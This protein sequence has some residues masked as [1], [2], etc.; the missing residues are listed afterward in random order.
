MKKTTFK[1]IASIVLV[2]MML[3]ALSVTAFAAD[4]TGDVYQDDSKTVVSGNKIP[5]TKS[6]VMFNLN[7]SDVYEP[8]ITYTY[9]VAPVTDPSLL[10]KITD[11]GEFNSNI[12]VTV[13]V[14]AGIAGS[15]G[16]DTGKNTISYS[17][18]NAVVTTD[19][20]GVAV[21]K[22]TEITVALSS[23]THA[24][25]YRYKITEADNSAAVAA[26]GMV[27]GADYSSERY[28]DVYISNPATG[29]TGFQLAGAVIFKTDAQDTSTP[30]NNATDQITT[31]TYKTTGFEPG[32]PG[33]ASGNIDYTSDTSSDHYTTYDFTVKK[34]VSGTLADKTNQ[35]P[36]YVNI[37]NTIA[38]A[39]YTYIGNPGTGTG[40]KETVA[41][42]T[43]TITKGT[44][45][46][47]ST[48]QLKDGESVKFVGVPSNQTAATPLTVAVKEFNNTPDEYKASAAV[49]NGT[50]PT[51]TMDGDASATKMAA[52]TGYATLAAFDLKTND[53]AGQI[54][55]VTN[56]IEQISPTGYV[57]R[58]AP[59]ALLMGCGIALVPVIRNRREEEDEA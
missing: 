44:D 4:T 11:D 2:V 1:K 7:G 6:I 21:E 27:R 48:L 22:S 15:V 17:S 10:G 37:T 8:N 31:T 33:S 59:Y 55:T 12:P 20:D 45:S 57:T 9:S 47:S 39:A 5:M 13:K 51:V 35:F 18:D 16:F 56:T 19:A 34:A 14:N 29:E 3:A 40:T 42:G 30:K 58:F 23:F 52:T 54:I 24:G 36:F 49:V 50:A 32:T 46:V 25:V 38:G 43:T 28:L 26:A 41:A 53:A